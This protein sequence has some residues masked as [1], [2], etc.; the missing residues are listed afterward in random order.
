[1]RAL[2]TLPEKVQSPGPSLVSQAPHCS[3][4]TEAVALAFWEG[5]QRPLQESSVD[6]PGSPSGLWKALPLPTSASLPWTLPAP[7]STVLRSPAGLA[8][9]G[10]SV[11]Q[12]HPCV[13]FQGRCRWDA[14]AGSPQGHGALPAHSAGRWWLLPTSSYSSNR[15]SHGRSSSAS[16]GA[17]PASAKAPPS[18]S[19]TAAASATSP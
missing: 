17:C 16:R 7:T 1:M 6:G 18:S 10:T 11:P 9:P 19:W 13:T 4:P 5:T 3:P 12:P 15:P 2:R 8:Q 14:E